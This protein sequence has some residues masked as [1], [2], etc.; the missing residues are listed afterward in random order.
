MIDV[1]SRVSVK[2]PVRDVFRF[3]NDASNEPKWHTDVLEVKP[4][5]SGPA[6]PG[7]TFSLRFKP[8]MG[9]SAGTMKIL[10]VEQNRRLV[11]QIDLGPMHPRVTYT[12]GSEGAMT[13]VSRRVQVEPPGMMK[14][15]PFM[16]KRMVRKKGETFLLNLKQNLEKE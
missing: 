8:M 9:H 4:A 6:A 16:M 13:T 1:E 12:F 2:R 15:M 5:S 14:L 10:E 7:A 3:L 11:S